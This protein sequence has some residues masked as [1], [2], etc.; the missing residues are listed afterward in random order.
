[1]EIDTT[2][3]YPKSGLFPSSMTCPTLTNLMA[4]KL[5]SVYKSIESASNK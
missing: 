2:L 4:A 3:Q 5:W 1:M